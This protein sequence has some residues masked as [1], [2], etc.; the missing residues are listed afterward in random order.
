M[1]WREW[2]LILGLSCCIGK[3]QEAEEYPEYWQE[4]IERKTNAGTRIDF[5]YWKPWE[6]YI[7]G[8]PWQVI[9]DIAINIKR[10]YLDSLIDPLSPDDLPGKELIRYYLVVDASFRALGGNKTID[11]AGD[12][13]IKDKNKRIWA[14]DYEGREVNGFPKLGKRVSMYEKLNPGKLKRIYPKSSYSDEITVSASRESVI[15]RKMCFAV[16]ENDIYGEGRRIVKYLDNNIR[17]CYGRGSI[18]LANL[19]NFGLQEGYYKIQNN[20]VNVDPI[21]IKKYFQIIKQFFA[22][23]LEQ[24]IDFINYKIERNKCGEPFLMFYFNSSRLGKDS[25]YVDI[26]KN[27]R[28]KWEASFTYYFYQIPPGKSLDDMRPFRCSSFEIE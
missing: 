21:K 7:E 5:N 4:E 26:Y 14:S 6:F 23:E 15:S 1:K 16:G 11:P 27:E 3:A 18:L 17:L 19:D 8:G 9:D 12:F 22:T 2:L 10:V 25:V 24:E 28:G 13:L 20:I